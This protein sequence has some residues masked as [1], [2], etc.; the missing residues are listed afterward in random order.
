M[1]V[2]YDYVTDLVAYNVPPPPEEDVVDVVDE[3][4]IYEDDIYEVDIYEVDIYDDYDYDI[5]EGALFLQMQQWTTQ[6]HTTLCQLSLTRS[7]VMP[8]VI[9]P[10]ECL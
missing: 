9:T 4:D 1:V 3:D 8:L 10:T 6:K 7:V 5:D 2:G